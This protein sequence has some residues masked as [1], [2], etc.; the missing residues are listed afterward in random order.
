MAGPM[1]ADGF[2][3][4]IAPER[5]FMI[6]NSV[7]TVNVIEVALVSDTHDEKQEGLFLRLKY[8]LYRETD[9]CPTPVG[10]NIYFHLSEHQSLDIA[11]NLLGAIQAISKR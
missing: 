6:K 1:Y 8:E 2:R 10:G 3:G 9:G 11:K 5:D 7:A 4:A